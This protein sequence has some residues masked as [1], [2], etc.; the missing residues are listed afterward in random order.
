MGAAV[1]GAAAGGAADGGGAAGEE[2]PSRCRA[3]VNPVFD[4]GL[5]YEL[6][7]IMIHSGSALGGH[8][9]AYIKYGETG[10]EREGEGE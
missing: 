3:S 9:F 4:D 2:G 1:G 5:H 7:S 6:F 10:R 8:Y